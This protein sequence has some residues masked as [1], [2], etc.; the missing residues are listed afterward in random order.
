MRKPWIY[1]RFSFWMFQL[2]PRGPKLL[3][4][5]LYG[6]VNQLIF[7]V[8]PLELQILNCTG[9]E[10][11]LLWVFFYLNLYQIKT[12]FLIVLIL[13]HHKFLIL[14]KFKHQKLSI[15][16]ELRALSHNRI[17]QLNLLFQFI[18]H[19]MYYKICFYKWFETHPI[20]K[21]TAILPTPIWKCCRIKITQ[22]SLF[23]GWLYSL[24]ILE[25]NSEVW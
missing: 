25:R 2:D 8:Q 6:K 11:V 12:K 17:P 1:I 18:K 21:T 5:W 13:Y 23:D 3:L 4:I 7:L 9:P 14:D 22:F 19:L 10:K 16:N 20:H 24:F 15:I